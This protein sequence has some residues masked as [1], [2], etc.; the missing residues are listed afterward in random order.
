MSTV[1]IGLEQR[2]L[3]ERHAEKLSD[4][5]MALHASSTDDC[6][7]CGRKLGGLLGTFRWGF[8]NGQGECSACGYPYVYY[9]RQEVES[10]ETLVLKAWVPGVPIPLEG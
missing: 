2:V 9:H 3:A 4:L 8:V 1:S 10:G 7:D 6:V 5:V